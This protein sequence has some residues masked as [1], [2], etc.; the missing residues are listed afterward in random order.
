M[1]NTELEEAIY[2]KYTV[3]LDAI[4]WAVSMQKAWHASEMDYGHQM[5]LALMVR[6]ARWPE[7]GK[8]SLEVPATW[9]EHLKEHLRNGRYWKLWKWLKVRYNVHEVE[10]WKILPAVELPPDLTRDSFDV[11]VNMKGERWH[12][13][14][15]D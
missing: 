10:A 15:L 1:H 9:W 2:Q 11:L 8:A 5:A 6:F 14:N 4:R 7:C 12:Y 13:D 3:Q